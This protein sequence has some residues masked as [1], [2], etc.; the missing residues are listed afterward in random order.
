MLKH[1]DEENLMKEVL[2]N[3][4]DT[5][6]ECKCPVCGHIMRPEDTDRFTCKYCGEQI[7]HE[8]IRL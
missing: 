6:N 8:T 2:K 5:E 1:G 4:V 3:N 7:Y